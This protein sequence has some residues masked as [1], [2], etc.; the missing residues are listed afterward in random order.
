M[1]PPAG[2]IFSRI[3]GGMLCCA[4]WSA[5][6]AHRVEW[7]QEWRA[8][9]WHARKSIRIDGEIHWAS[10][11]E[12]LLFCVGAFQDALALRRLDKKEPRTAFHGS[13]AECLLLLLTLFAASYLLS[14]LLPGVRAESHPSLYRVNPDLIMI[15]NA[16]ASDDSLATISAEQYKLWKTRR[17]RYFDGFAFYRIARETVIGREAMKERWRVAHGSLNLLWMLGLP[18]LSSALSG[19]AVGKTPGVILSEATWRRDFA[20]DP[21]IAGRAIRIGRAEARVIGVA[22][23]GAWRLPGSLDAWLLEPDDV[24]RGVGYVIAHLTPAGRSEMNSSRVQIISSNTDD[25]DEEL[26]GVSFA[27]RSKGPW[28]LYQFALLLAFLA[29]PA[30][31]SV[32][33]GESHFCSYRPPW[34]NRLCHWLF[35]GAKITL[36]LPAIYF[37]SLDLAYWHTTTF[38]IGSQYIQLISTFAMT[39]FGLRWIISDQRNRCPVCLRRVTHPAQVGLAGRTFLAW[40]GTE[41]MCAGGHTLLHVPALP[42][43]WFGTQRWLYLDTSWQF[44]FS[45]SNVG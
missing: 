25:T 3:E 27:D 20:G 6:T 15:Q 19:D 9:L 21:H 1:T 39:L 29:L 33:L 31:T 4:S 44:L 5:P 23:A 36:L 40:N 13:A 45:G 14:Q 17:Q 38:S 42:T 32:S 2:W 26:Y 41:L 24:N 7:L 18:T 8:E 12:I 43:S 34:S 35:L 28:G 37:A 22:P 10:E 16:F 30:V 11:K